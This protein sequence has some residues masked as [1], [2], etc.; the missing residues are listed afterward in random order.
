[1]RVFYQKGIQDTSIY[2]SVVREGYL[3]VSDPGKES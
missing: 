2:F 3:M 1:M